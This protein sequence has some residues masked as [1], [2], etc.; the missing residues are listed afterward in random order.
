M[1]KEKSQQ[2]AFGRKQESA[3]SHES[4]FLKLP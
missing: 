3:H 2:K 4:A 1:Q